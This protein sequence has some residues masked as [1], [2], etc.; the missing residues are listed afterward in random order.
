VADFLAPV[1]L[2]I[3]AFLATNIDDLFILMV[4]FANRRFPASQIVLGQ[5]VG[6]GSLLA[7]SLLGL[8]IALVVPSNQRR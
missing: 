3:G 6:M 4:F 8:L 1:G 7:V 5:Y 2:G